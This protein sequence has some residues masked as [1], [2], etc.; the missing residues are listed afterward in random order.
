MTTTRPPLSYPYYVCPKDDNLKPTIA[1]GEGQTCLGMLHKAYESIEGGGIAKSSRLM[2]VYCSPVLIYVAPC[3]PS[4]T[5]SDD[6]K[7]TTFR[8]IG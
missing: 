1:L 6:E 8:L 5:L 3:L 7:M 4:V 2:N